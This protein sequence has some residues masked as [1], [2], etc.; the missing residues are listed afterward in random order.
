[1]SACFRFFLE[2]C[3]LL[4]SDVFTSD[5]SLDNRCLNDWKQCS[6]NSKVIHS[7]DSS[8]CLSDTVAERL[9]L[10]TGLNKWKQC[11]YT[12]GFSTIQL[13]IAIRFHALYRRSC[14]V[15][16]ERRTRNR[17]NTISIIT[18]TWAIIQ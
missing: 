8:K 16:T 9:V 2:I 18:H 10:R 3:H 6:Y 5:C 12:R 7:R 17:S 13:L 11:S 15:L 14:I 1:L 4:F